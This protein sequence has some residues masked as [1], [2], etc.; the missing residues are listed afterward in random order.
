[1]FL[2]LVAWACLNYLPYYTN[3]LY[4]NGTIS[5]ADFAIFELL[6]IITEVVLIIAWFVVVCANRVAISEVEFDSHDDFADHAGSGA[7]EEA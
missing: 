3:Q 2:L 5:D 4:F 7:G 1:M 6:K